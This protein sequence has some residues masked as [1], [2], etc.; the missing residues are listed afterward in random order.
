M[1]QKDK[2]ATIMVGTPITAYFLCYFPLAL[3]VIGLIVFFAMTDSD[4]RR[5]YL[6][7]NPFKEPPQ[8]KELE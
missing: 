8:R 2:E 6:R 4:A 3:T 7:E 5:P 1:H